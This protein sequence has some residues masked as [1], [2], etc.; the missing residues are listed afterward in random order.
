MKSSTVS[1]VHL[2]ASFG[3]YHAAKGCFLGKHKLDGKE[4]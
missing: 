3:F 2:G 1:S 4:E